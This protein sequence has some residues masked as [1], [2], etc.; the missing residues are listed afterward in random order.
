MCTLKDQRQNYESNL[1]YWLHI[2]CTFFYVSRLRMWN[3]SELFTYV[4]TLVVWSILFLIL[5]VESYK[6]G[7]GNSPWGH[8]VPLITDL[9][10]V[11][12]DQMDENLRYTYTS[13]SN[14][15]VYKKNGP[16]I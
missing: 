5:I 2:K 8:G 10:L 9:E 13:K 14:I 4:S 3:Y 6:R 7:Q 16:K 15:Y 11:V 12:S 1:C